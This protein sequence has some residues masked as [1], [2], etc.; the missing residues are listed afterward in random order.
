MRDFAR[1]NRLRGYTRHRRKDDLITF[2]RNNYQPAPT[3]TL[4]PPAGSAQPP[5]PTLE[6][7]RP[8]CTRP[9]RPMRPPPPLA[10]PLVRFRTDRPKQPELLRQLE[11][12]NP[13]PQP[14]GSTP[15][16]RPPALKPYQ[17]KPKRGQE[18]FI[19]PPVEL[20]A[21]PPPNAKQVKRMKEKL[22][23]LNKKIRH[24]KR[25]HNN[26]VSKQNSIIEEGQRTERTTRA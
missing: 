11:E 13:Q 5:P 25:K 4:R 12:R 1:E 16:R 23:K 9:P 19:E 18:T 7:T 14:V 20:K 15:H 6:P 10:L 22:G 8:Q 21:P 26:L 24:S 2:L 3:P 17:L